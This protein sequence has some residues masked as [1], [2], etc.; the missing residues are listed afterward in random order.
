MPEIIWHSHLSLRHSRF[1]LNGKAYEL[2]GVCEHQ[3]FAGVGVA[4]NQDIVDYKIKIMK[5]MG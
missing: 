1:Y 3:D 4:L 2:R 5:E